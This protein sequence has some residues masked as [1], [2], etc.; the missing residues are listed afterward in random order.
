MQSV[1][2]AGGM[3]KRLTPITQYIQKCMLPVGK[4]EK[5]VL[6]FIIKLMRHHKIHDITLLAGYRSNQIINYFNNGERFG[7]NINYVLDKKSNAGTASARRGAV[8]REAGPRRRRRH[9]R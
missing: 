5:P 1:I 7:V 2:L 8:M 4:G 9:R 6:E 3:G